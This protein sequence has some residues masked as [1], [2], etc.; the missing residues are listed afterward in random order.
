[1]TQSDTSPSGMVAVV[2]A[3]ALSRAIGAERDAAASMQR[4]VTYLML[5]RLVLISLVLG[6]T[7][8]LYKLGNVD[9]SEVASLMLFAIIGTTYLLTIVYSV[10]LK[11]G[12]NAAKLANTQIL[13]DLITTTLLV[14]VTGGAQSGY[15]FFFTFSIVGA[16]AVR[17]RTGAIVVTIISMVLFSAVATLGWVELLP[18]PAGQQLLPSDIRP[19][20]FTR[21]LAVNLIAFTGVGI[22]AMNLGAQIQTT[23]ASLA[24]ERTA[25]A[26][27]Y[28]LHEDIVRCLSSGLVTIDPQDHVSS[29]NQSACEIL[30]VASHRALGSPVNELLPGIGLKLSRLSPRQ[31]LRRSDL[32][33]P[34]EGRQDITLGITVSPL[35]DNSDAV[36][37]RI[38]NFQDLTELR[39]MERQIKRAERLAVVGTLAAGIAH[40]IRNPLAS[41][42]GS[43]ELLGSVGGR[44]GDDQALMEIITREIDR[45][46]ALISDLLDYTNPHPRESVAFDI[47]E[48]VQET[49][50][51]FR[52]DRAFEGVDVKT[53]RD[54]VQSGVR[55]QGDPG[56][57]RQV[58]WNLTR[59]AAQAAMSGQGHV[60]VVVSATPATVRIEVI[61]D[62]PG[63]EPDVIDRIFDPFFTTR[64]RGSGLGLATCHSILQ[65]LGGSIQA[66]NL[67]AGGCRF[68]VLLPMIPAEDE[69]IHSH[70]KE[71]VA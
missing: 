50:R 56:R 53:S 62:G 28:A 7:L 70:S 14:H 69:P 15:S 23:S 27:L 11:F 54:S 49:L 57:L 33:L 18:T 16:A 63:I 60:E 10:A 13:V 34:R 19:I 66:D 44:G 2:E 55:L 46:N 67:R 39:E 5:F 22:L 26:D 20:K 35:R 8:V 31:S 36:V 25:A 51:V 32:S 40:E 38:L 65:E 37:G 12:A 1:M 4:R 59:N 21:D 71:S 47:A 41:I 6:T 30:G 42:S 24:T 43:V 52:Q 64:S 45:L 17:F 68:T 48:L 29:I 9:L 3:A 58:V 61:D